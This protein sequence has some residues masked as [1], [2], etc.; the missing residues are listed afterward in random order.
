MIG[1]VIIRFTSYI[2]AFFGWLFDNDI[3]QEIAQ[4]MRTIDCNPITFLKRVWSD[5]K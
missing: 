5:E 2:F 1:F 4:D 3:N